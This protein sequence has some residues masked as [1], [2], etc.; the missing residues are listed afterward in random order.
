MS[1]VEDIVLIMGF[2]YFFL[3]ALDYAGLISITSWAVLQE[4][5]SHKEAGKSMTR[6]VA[7]TKRSILTGG[8]WTGRFEGV[9]AGAGYREDF[10]KFVASF[11]ELGG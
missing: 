5:N 11:K 2:P 6:P 3:R 4:M 9:V 8:L 1:R 7:A 10:A